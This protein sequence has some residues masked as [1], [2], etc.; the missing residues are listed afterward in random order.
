MPAILQAGQ[1]AAGPGTGRLLP[2][3]AGGLLR[4]HRQRARH[5]LAGG[6]FLV[7]AGVSGVP[8]RDRE[9]SEDDK[10]LGTI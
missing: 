3:A 5:R 8:K 10:R 7:A 1:V 9:M 2:A 4:R 6:R